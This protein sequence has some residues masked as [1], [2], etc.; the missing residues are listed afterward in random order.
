MDGDGHVST[1]GIVPTW[2][3]QEATVRVANLKDSHEAEIRQYINAATSEELK[4]KEY[5]KHLTQ[6]RVELRLERQA[7][8][9]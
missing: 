2:G 1:A 8:T 9:E 6:A 5:Q 4:A 7:R 3:A